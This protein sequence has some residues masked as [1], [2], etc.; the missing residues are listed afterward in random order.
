MMDTKKAGRVMLV[1]TS[2]DLD[3]SARTAAMANEIV[4]IAIATRT[5]ESENG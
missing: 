1:Y 3:H 5:T 4:H 2:L